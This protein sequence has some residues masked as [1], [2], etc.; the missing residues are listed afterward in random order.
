M[1]CS[2]YSNSYSP[3]LSHLHATL[4]ISYTSPVQLLPI[5]NHPSI[6]QF[7]TVCVGDCRI[8]SSSCS[9]SCCL[10][11]AERCSS[12]FNTPN[13]P[14]RN[15]AA[16]IYSWLHTNQVLQRY[17][18]KDYRDNTVMDVRVTINVKWEV[19]LGK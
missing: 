5:M 13:P 4:H 15:F 2:I 19:M 10:T 8:R 6:K 7:R 18:P 11:L 16:T 12:C 3:Y 14:A 1:W 17:Q 9:S